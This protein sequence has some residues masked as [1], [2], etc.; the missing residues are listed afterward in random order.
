MDSRRRPHP[1]AGGS[2]STYVFIPI[3]FHLGGPPL[4]QCPVDIGGG[5]GAKNWSAIA[6]RLPG[7]SN[8]DSRK[9]WTK[10][11]SSSRK[12]TWSSAEDHLLRKGVA[13]FGFQ[14]V[15]GSSTLLSYST[16]TLRSSGGQKLQISLSVVILTV[17]IPSLIQYIAMV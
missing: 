1:P 6:E 5:Q 2:D 16:D 13:I 14:C 11:A 8:K 17:R 10:I 7:R 9:R 4:T 15:N 3:T 12:G